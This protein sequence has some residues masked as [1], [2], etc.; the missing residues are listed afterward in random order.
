M[1][2]ISINSSW[3]IR[4]KNNCIFGATAW[5]CWGFFI[6]MCC[7][8]QYIANNLLILCTDFYVELGLPAC[9]RCIFDTHPLFLILQG[10]PI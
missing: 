5:S 7:L 6:C 3:E 1:D 2:F 8:I 10:S 9:S 4:C